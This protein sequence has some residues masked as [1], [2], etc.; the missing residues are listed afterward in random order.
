MRRR[1]SREGVRIIQMLFPWG[2]A[3]LMTA[4]DSRGDEVLDQTDLLP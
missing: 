1:Q 4:S 2:T 3:R